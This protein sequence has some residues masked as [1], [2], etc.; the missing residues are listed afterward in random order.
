MI[1]PVCVFMVLLAFIV[2]I[3]ATARTNGKVGLA[4]P[5]PTTPRI[6]QQSVSA[7]L[8]AVCLA[9]A[10]MQQ[11]TTKESTA[12]LPIMTLVNGGARFT[13]A[14]RH[15]VVHLQH[16]ATAADV[17]MGLPFL[18]D[19][20]PPATLHSL[21]YYHRSNCGLAMSTSSV[22][23]GLLGASPLSIQSLGARPFGVC[24][25][26]MCSSNVRV[27]G[28]HSFDLHSLDQS[29]A[30]STNFDACLRGDYLRSPATC[31]VA[32]CWA[33]PNASLLSRVSIVLAAALMHR[34]EGKP[35][36]LLTTTTTCLR[37]SVTSVTSITSVAV[38]VLIS[39][40]LTITFNE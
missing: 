5:G 4:Y 40:S 8:H 2:S 22:N 16:A 33:P 35:T 26:G 31:Q 14:P 38:S 28:L 32:P 10:R 36:T 20:L 37:F 24:F 23:S 3:T 29:I 12:L 39:P 7:P 13:E 25:L 11:C 21:H 34:H 17:A 1:I 19:G 30:S 9:S 15:G 27:F 6:L 18:V